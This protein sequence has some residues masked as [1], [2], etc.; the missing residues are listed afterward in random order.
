MSDSNQGLAANP[1]E[2]PKALFAVALLF[3]IFQIVTAAFHPVSSQ[4]LRAVH[5]GFLLLV[6]FISFPG[7][8][9]GQP[10]QPLAWLIGLAGMGTAFYQWYFEA[11]LIQR[12]GDLTSMDMAVG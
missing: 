5:V 2:W 1:G 10:W 7:A 9:K 4:V 8:G 11:D 6:V 3:S 12:S